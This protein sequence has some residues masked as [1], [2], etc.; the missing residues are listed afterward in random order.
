MKIP[1]ATQTVYFTVVGI[2]DSRNT[3]RLA[4]VVIGKA[5]IG[6]VHF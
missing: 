6:N 2:W 5:Y 3:A 1:I 4:T